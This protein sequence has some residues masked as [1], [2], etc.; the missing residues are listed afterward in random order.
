MRR[1]QV[2]ILCA[3]HFISKDMKL[4]PQG[5]SNKSWLW[6]VQGDFADNEAKEQLFAVKFG[7]K[8]TALAFKRAF[9]ECLDNKVRLLNEGV[10]DN[11]VI[12]VYDFSVTEEQRARA[13]KFLLPPNFYAYENQNEAV[14]GEKQDIQET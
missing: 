13:A 8:D 2:H 1:D 12:V 5:S 9:E 4:Q 10:L 3:N 14:P 6:H 7:D 11:E